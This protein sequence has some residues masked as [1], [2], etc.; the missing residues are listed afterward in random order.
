[1]S[2][3]NIN[4]DDKKKLKKAN[5]TKIKKYFEQMILMLAKYKFLK[6]NDTAKR[7]HLNTL[8]DIMIMTLLDHYV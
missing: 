7:M 1:M 6:K 3:K 5:F 4:F 2:G 8:L